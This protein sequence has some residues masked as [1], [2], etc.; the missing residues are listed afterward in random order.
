MIAA[1][2][3]AL[4]G[5]FVSFDF[6]DSLAAP[7]AGVRAYMAAYPYDC[8]EQRLSKVVV[9]G[10]IGGWT[11]LAGAL[12]TYLDGEGLVRY[13]PDQGMP[14]SPELTAYVLATTSAAG[15]PLPDAARGRIVSGLKGVV[16]GRISR[17]RAFDADERL[18][19]ISALAALARAGAADPGLVAQIDMVPA[20][21]PTST[22]ADWIVTLDRLPRAPRATA[23]RTAAEGE[24]RRRLVYEGTRLDLADA[25]RAPWWMMTSADEMAIKAL[26]A[27]IGKPGW[28]AE[29]PKMMAGMAARQWRGHW[30]TTPANA[31]GVLTTR[32]FAAAYQP[33]PIT[34]TTYAGLGGKSLSLGWPRKDA[35]KPL[36]L[37]LVNGPLTLKQSGGAGP[38]ATVTVNAAVPLTQ[39]L[40]AGYRLSRSISV[41]SAKQKGRWSQGD[42]I[43]V[44]LTVVATAE[45][46]WVALTDP[47]PPGATVLSSLGGQSAV[48]QQ[49][50]QTQGAYPAYT[51]SDRGAWRAYYDWLP[52]GTTVI[53][54]TLRLNSSGSF[55]LPPARVEA[56][57]AP[58][59]RSQL[60]IAPV[61]VWPS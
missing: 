14:G 17:N 55:T 58:S 25:N 49:G 44:R 23:L 39:P 57:Y 43:R 8:F 29:V 40:N 18:V 42:V 38:W 33:A 1:P 9:S 41:I 16:E 30:D 4:P 32:R 22:L 35:T 56:M 28:S 48:L 54:Y 46:N 26:D 45:R 52:R 24:L 5:G 15:L 3:G 21:M 60:P 34:G 13:W 2:A 19:R 37:P 6:S 59:I 47:L 20:D 12:P 36:T 50:E 27:V 31:W 10:D 51:Q 61:T 11:S 7:L 53:E